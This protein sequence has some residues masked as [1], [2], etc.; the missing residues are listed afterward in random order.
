MMRKRQLAGLTS[1]LFLLTLCLAPLSTNNAHYLINYL[2]L[3][4]WDMQKYLY[5]VTILL[6]PFMYVM[7]KP[8][9]S[10]EH[11][12]RLRGSLFSYIMAQALKDSAFCTSAVYLC[13]AVSAL[14]SGY[15]ISADVSYLQIIPVLFMFILSCHLLYHASYCVSEKPVLSLFLPYMLNMLYLSTV[16]AVNFYLYNNSFTDEYEFI[17][18]LLYTAAVCIL[19]VITLRIVTGRKE[20]LKSENF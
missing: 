20:F 18:F 17:L 1:M 11:L 6:I 9:L 3:Y 12:I 15:Q 4:L 13:F 14:P 19:S 5:F 7:K 8:Y 16:I 10:A 2:L